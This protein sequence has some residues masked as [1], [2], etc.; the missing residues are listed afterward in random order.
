MI[1]RFVIIEDRGKCRIV[2]QGIEVLT[3]D[4]ETTESPLLLEGLGLA[5]SGVALDHDRVDDEAVLIALHLA[6]HVGLGLRRAVVV[7]DT[8]TTLKSHVD[9]HVMLGDSVHRRRDKGCLKRD[10]LG[11][12]RVEADG[13]GREANVAGQQEEVV[14]SETTLHLGVHQILNT[15]AITA[16]VLLQVLLSLG[17]VEDLGRSPVGLLRA[18]LR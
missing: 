9:G 8:E 7:N 13:R 11:D 3:C 2:R 4:G 17:V 5:N 12:G 10:T 16:L 18:V 14:V 1:Y 6:N 15:E